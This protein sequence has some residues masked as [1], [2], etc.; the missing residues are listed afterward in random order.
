MVF[1]FY[2][3]LFQSQKFHDNSNPGIS[4][5]LRVYSQYTIKEMPT[6]IVHRTRA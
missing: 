2:H 1:L 4:D 6:F 3:R 5:T